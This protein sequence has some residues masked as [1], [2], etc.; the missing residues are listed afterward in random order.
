MPQP[1][2][3][4]T[5]EA[6]ISRYERRCEETQLQLRKLEEEE[7]TIQ[8]RLG[9]IPKEKNRLYT[10]MCKQRADVKTSKSKAYELLRAQ[11]D[12]GPSKPPVEPAHRRKRERSLSHCDLAFPDPDSDIE[13]V[14]APVNVKREPSPIR[15]RNLRYTMPIV[16]TIIIRSG[17]TTGQ[18]MSDHPR[19]LGYRRLRKTL[20]ESTQHRDLPLLVYLQPCPLQQQ[21]CRPLLHW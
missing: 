5:L 13:V 18:S 9:E 21:D 20:A 19:R 11:L 3:L 15:V 8:Q 2:D 12:A 16:L 7:T 4:E 1:E 10:K 14:E 17:T 6:R